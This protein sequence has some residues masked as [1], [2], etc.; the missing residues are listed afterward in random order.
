MNKEIIVK[1]L[2]KDISELAQL[3]QGFDEI[4]VLPTILL[5]LAQQKASAIVE[6]L[7]LLT[8]QD[9]QATKT[10]NSNQPDEPAIPET[11]AKDQ[12]PIETEKNK[13]E[14]PTKEETAEKP[15]PVSEK[16]EENVIPEMPAI[17]EEIAEC[18]EIVE[19]AVLEEEENAGHEIQTV[20]EET[21]AEEPQP[22]Q[23][24][25]TVAPGTISEEP[26]KQPERHFFQHEVITRNDSLQ[27][28]VDDVKQAISIG[29][30]FLFQRELFGGNGELMSKTITVINACKDLESA[31]QYLSKKFNWNPDSP[32]TERFMQ[33]VRRKF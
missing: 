1:L 5:Q 13:K 8:G 2:Q 19:T 30:R 22:Q 33:I 29:D 14:T 7:Q 32:A 15:E 11:E 6:N 28:K 3:T 23:I 4:D 9:A 17:E 24:A 16:Q 21:A 26:A 12:T 10:A 27:H 18:T 25:E 31:E 20:S